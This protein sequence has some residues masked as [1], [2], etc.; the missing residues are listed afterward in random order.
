MPDALDLLVV[1]AEAGLS[2]D[3]AIDQVSRD[4]RLSHPEVAEEFE[5]T[6]AEMRVAPDRGAALDS[7]VR[8]TNLETLR[9]ITAT[10]TQAIRFGTPLAESLRVLAAEMRTARIL[11]IEERAARLP[12]LLTIPLLCFILPALFIVIGTPVVL[13]I[14]DFF[15]H[16]QIGGQ[17]IL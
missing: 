6:A 5:I 17:G 16:L 8:R 2:L 7:L 3:Q 4:L 14:Y 13:R 15:K 11:K 10:L 9:S 12:V 1:C